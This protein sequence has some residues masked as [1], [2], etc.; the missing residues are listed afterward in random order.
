MQHQILIFNHERPIPA[1]PSLATLGIVP[2]V[3]YQLAIISVSLSSTSGRC[4]LE[5]IKVVHRLD[6]P[7]SVVRSNTL[8]KPVARSGA[9]GT[10]SRHCFALA[11][12]NTNHLK[13]RVDIDQM[14]L[15]A[16]QTAVEGSI[17]LKASKLENYFTGKCRTVEPMKEPQ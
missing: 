5:F 16:R 7:A 2:G 6:Q 11:K 3:S 9:R 13:C 15:G 10:R 14:A 4:K 1:G 12:A 17:D 8:P